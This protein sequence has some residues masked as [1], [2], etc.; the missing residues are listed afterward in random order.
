MTIPT[1]GDVKTAC[2]RIAGHVRS[3]TV[4]RADPGTVCDADLWLVLEFM[5][6]TGSFKAR[7]AANFVA[8]HLE[9]CTMPDSGVV[10]ASGG[11]AGLACAWAAKRHGVTATVFLPETAPPVKVAKLRAYD[12]DVRQVGDEYADALDAAHSHAA[13]T[14]AIESHAYDNPLVAAGAGTLV[15]EILTAIPDALDTIVVAVGGGGLFTGV[16]VAADHYGIHVVAVE[17]VNCRAL[18]AAIESGQLVDVPVN[19][20]AADA[21]GARRTSAM[22]LEWAGRAAVHSVLVPDEAII[23]ARHALWDH[24]RLAVEHGAATALAALLNGA[25]IPKAGEKIAVVLCGANTDPTD[26][27]SS[28]G[29]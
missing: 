23:H 11:N 29:R 8:A 9:A 17:P 18:N 26:L 19:S 21:L 15:P 6:Y 10:I 24:R 25:Y 5:Q 14:G 4:T 7:G 13:T 3:V 2:D 16:T 22:A 1:Y 20:I 27:V 12:A 28:Q